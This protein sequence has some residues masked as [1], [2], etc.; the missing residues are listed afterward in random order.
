MTRSLPLLLA[1][2][3]ATAFVLGSVITRL[4]YRAYRR[5]QEPALRTFTT[6]IGL[7][8]IGLMIGGA[9]HQVLWP[10]LLVGTVVQSLFSVGGFAMLVYSA[11]AKRASVLR[12]VAQ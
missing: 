4:A 3:N 6:G 10:G 1:V 11:Y 2:M 7:L 5:T 12:L 8:T 9:L